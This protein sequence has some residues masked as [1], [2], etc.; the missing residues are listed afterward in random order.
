MNLKPLDDMGEAQL[1]NYLE[2][3]LWHYKVAD[4]FWFIKTSER[5][6]QTTAEELNREVWA[7][8]GE[9]AAKEIKKRFNIAEKGLTGFLRAQELYPWAILIGYDFKF[10]DNE[11]YLTVASCPSQQARLKRGLSEYA[12]KEMHRAEFL[13]FAKVIDERIDVECVFAP[14]DVHPKDVFCKW[15]F[16][17]N[18]SKNG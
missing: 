12:C 3:L 16:Y 4:A 6:G 9:L 5:F 1:R 10:V 15:R 11:L 7:K 2:F 8:A 13:S 14:P 18:E 17:L